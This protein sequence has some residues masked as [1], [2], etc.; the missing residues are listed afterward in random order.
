MMITAGD[1][2]LWLSGCEVEGK[3][4]PLIIVE[5]V[6]GL[7]AWWE[8]NYAA[9]VWKESRVLKI[10]STRIAN[11]PNGNRWLESYLGSAVQG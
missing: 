9:I 11:T 4:R 7:E 1:C 2:G 3:E 10:L 6:D 8:T 5:T